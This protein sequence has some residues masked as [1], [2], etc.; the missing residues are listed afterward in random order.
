MTILNLLTLLLIFILC[1]LKYCKLLKNINKLKN[2]L[3]K[4]RFNYFQYKKKSYKNSSN[5]LLNEIQ[6]RINNNLQQIKSILFIIVH[7]NNYISKELLILREFEKRVEILNII[8]DEFLDNIE[9]DFVIIMNKIIDQIL[10][11]ENLSNK[12][13]KINIKS[14]DIDLTFETASLLGL[15][16][17]ELSS[18]SIRYSQ[19]TNHLDISLTKNFDNQ[20]ILF[21]NDYGNGYNHLNKTVDGIGFEII[22][23]IVLQLKAIIIN[24][25]KLKKGIKIIF[26]Q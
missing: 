13:L 17:Y 15:L 19:Y 24:K 18:N 25:S 20:I 5:E 4:T 23:L 1:F 6:H 14:Y 9:I 2:E 16:I 21:I 8:Q 12:N 22:E 3:E 7:K 26:N 10:I 11:N